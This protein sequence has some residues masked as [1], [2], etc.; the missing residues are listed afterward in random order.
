MDNISIDKY[1]LSKA[2]AEKKYQPEWGATKY[3]LR[4]KMFA[5]MGGDKN[6]TPIL[7]LKLEPVH[8]DLKR[9]Q[10]EGDI[11]PG[12]YMNKLHWNS[13]YYE[14]GVSD[15]DIKSMIDESHAILL[16]SLS[17]KVQAE[18]LGNEA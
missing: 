1:L 11:I 9:Q 8:G 2:G 6:E 5:M 12:Y 4:G 7:T 14:N 10:Y 16:K 15:D 18:I 17:K 13:I 3:M